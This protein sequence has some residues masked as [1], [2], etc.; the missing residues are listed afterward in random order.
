[1]SFCVEPRHVQSG[2]RAEA[3]DQPGVVTKQCTD[4]ASPV[5]DGCDPIVDVETREDLS[6]TQ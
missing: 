6:S 3:G 5:F 2:L 1:M 4:L